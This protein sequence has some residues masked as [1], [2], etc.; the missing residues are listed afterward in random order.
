LLCHAAKLRCFLIRAGKSIPAPGLHAQPGELDYHQ[1]S[2]PP[3]QVHPIRNGEPAAATPAA[4]R[5]V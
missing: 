3:G 2:K 5:V 1:L 4:A